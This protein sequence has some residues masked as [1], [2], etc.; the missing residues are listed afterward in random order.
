MRTYKSGP[1]EPRQVLHRYVGRIQTRC[2]SCIGYKLLV[3]TLLSPM[4]LSCWQ[5][6]AYP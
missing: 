5:N 3:N 6:L 4:R 2:I 1:V